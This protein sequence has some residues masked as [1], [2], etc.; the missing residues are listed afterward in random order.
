MNDHIIFDR[1]RLRLH[2]N[3]AAAHFAQHDF[4]LRQMAERLAERLECVKRRFP[5]ALDMGSHGILNEML[6]G[7]GGIETLVQMELSA[8]PNASSLRL[9][10]D[11]EWLPFA[12]SSFDLV[13][14]M[15]NLHWVNDLPGALIQIFRALKPDGM[16]LAMIPGAQ[17]LKELRHAFEQAEMEISGG[18][19]P[20]VAPFIDV[21]DGGSLLQRAGFS[22][23]VID[24][25]IVTVR[26]E[27]PFSLLQD[28][29]GMGETSALIQA[30]KGMAAKALIPLAMEK[31]SQLY[32]GEDGRVP[33]TFEFVTLTGWKPA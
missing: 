29:R 9:I 10:A 24:S 28:L 21:R 22:L 33:A 2:K 18:I 3:R 13:L 31:Y 8:Q 23:P 12:E 25:E 32:R 27:N 20:R 1:A 17:T 5:C 15:G 19:S 30:K 4:L 6:A 16:F 14:A 11:E 26:Y 7:R